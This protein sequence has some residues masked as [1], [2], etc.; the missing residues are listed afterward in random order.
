MRKFPES[1]V[2]FGRQ[3]I[4]VSP[5]SR[6]DSDA[7]GCGLLNKDR[8]PVQALAPDKAYPAYARISDKARCWRLNDFAESGRSV[9][10]AR[11]SVVNRR[12]WRA[13]RNRR[14]GGPLVCRFGAGLIWSRLRSRALARGWTPSSDG[15]GWRSKA[16]RPILQF[17]TTTFDTAAVNPRTSRHVDGFFGS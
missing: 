5:G 17:P 15:L 14:R 12:Q 9:C 10:D 1:L 8:T 3:S 6:L 16:D 4:F 11:L 7:P 2:A 13:T